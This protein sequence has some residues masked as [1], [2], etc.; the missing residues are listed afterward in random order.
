MAS[1]LRRRKRWLLR[2]IPSRARLRSF[3]LLRKIGQAS[4]LWSF[5]M[6]EVAPGFL[7]GWVLTLSPFLGLHTPLAILC[8]VLFRANLPIPLLLLLVSN[9]LALP[10]L[11]PALHAVGSAVVHLLAP[12]AAT[13]PRKFLSAGFHAV[14]VNTLAALLVGYACTA[15]SVV[16][17]AIGSRGGKRKNLPAAPPPDQRGSASAEPDNSGK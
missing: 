8:A 7:I 17:Y 2:L 14:A 15:I 1:R 11:W 4:F 6:R 5:R 12:D 3:P 13:G 16:L 10:F 9:P